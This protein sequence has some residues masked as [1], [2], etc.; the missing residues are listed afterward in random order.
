MFAVLLGACAVY[1]ATGEPAV[2]N[3]IQVTAVALMALHAARRDESRIA[4]GLLALSNVTWAIGD[5]DPFKLN[6]FYLVSYVFAH[7]GLVILVAA[8]AR[9]R[10]RTALALD[11]IVAG[12]AARDGADQLRPPRASTAPACACPPR[13][14]RATR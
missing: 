4:W 2:R 9:I 1:A 7:A 8:Q 5:F 10:W 11:G 14:W 13:R 3:A 12:L 6:A